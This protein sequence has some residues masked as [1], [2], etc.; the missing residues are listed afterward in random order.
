MKKV[1]SELINTQEVDRYTGIFNPHHAGS[2]R[3]DP[4]PVGLLA[5]GSPG[6]D[7]SP[8]GNSFRGKAERLGNYDLGRDKYGSPLFFP[9]SDA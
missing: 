7:G 1:M 5:E 2:V 8:H 9:N 6:P 4:G 3:H